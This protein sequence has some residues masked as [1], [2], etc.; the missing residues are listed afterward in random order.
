MRQPV[1]LALLIACKASS[2]DESAAQQDLTVSAAGESPSAIART[3][4][5]HAHGKLRFV[6]K[7]GDATQT[8]TYTVEADGNQLAFASD[9]VRIE[10]PGAAPVGMALAAL[11]LS[12]GVHGEIVG[13]A[14][15]ADEE[16]TNELRWLFVAW[17]DSPLGAGARWRYEEHFHT[18]VG[19]VTQTLDYQLVRRTA[20]EAEVHLAVDA[21][22]KSLGP[23]AHA[24]GVITVPLGEPWRLPRGS[25]S[26]SGQASGTLEIAPVD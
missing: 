26:F 8:R 21:Q 3:T 18:A 10:R 4:P 6:A 24:S 20:T 12:R 11:T 23:Y 13:P 14:D 2:Q 5:H 22:T 9:G 19:P 7:A 15:S 16:T 1:M 17:P 25:F